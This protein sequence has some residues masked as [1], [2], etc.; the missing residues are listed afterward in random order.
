MFCRFLLS[1][2]L[3]LS[4]CS[5]GL[6]AILYSE[7][8]A[9]PDGTPPS[10]WVL[11]SGTGGQTISSGA[12]AMAA[13]GTGAG[14][15]DYSR[16]FT[17]VTSGTVFGGFDVV[18]TS[19]PT[20]T[21]DNYFA[22]FVGQT[23][24]TFASRVFFNLNAGVTN[25][26]FSESTQPATQTLTSTPVNLNQTY[27]V[28]VGYDLGTGTSSFWLNPTVDGESA[29]LVDATGNNATSL[30]GFSFRLQN[31]SDGNKTIDNLIVATTFAEAANIT[32]VPEPT[33][34]ALVSLVGG[35]GLF[36]AYRKRRKQQG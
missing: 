11:T 4:W 34:I 36:A 25:F 18:L 7:S 33:S 17:A 5:I 16:P 15:G 23:A 21:G 31:T 35:S 8:F 26:A 3:C 28:V 22:H 12:L 27:R 1:S 29:L 2:L 9:Y 14:T 30:T 32:A 6:S 20:D 19:A 10:P 13:S 24:T